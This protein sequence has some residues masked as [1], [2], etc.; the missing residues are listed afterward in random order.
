[1]SM[2]KDVSKMEGVTT[3]NEINAQVNVVLVRLFD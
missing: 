3:F 1:M 2:G